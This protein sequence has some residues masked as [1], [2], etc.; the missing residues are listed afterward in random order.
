MANPPSVSRGITIKFH[1]SDFEACIVNVTPPN[2]SL[3]SLD[4]TRQSDNGAMKF[5]PAWFYDGGE[6]QLLIQFDP[7]E[8]PPII[9]DNPANEL[10]TI[11]FPDGL[12]QWEFLG[13]MNQ[14]S[15]NADLN[16][17]MQATVGVKVADD[18]S[19]TSTS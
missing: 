9:T 15:P 3:E 13:H 1:D 11:T 10:I 19:I 12:G 6:L 2:I 5:I 7:E 14:Y 8:Q 17:V 16:T 4:V 18:I